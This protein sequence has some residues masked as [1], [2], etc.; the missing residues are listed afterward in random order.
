[1]NSRRAAATAARGATG[2]EDDDRL[3]LDVDERRPRLHAAGVI[4]VLAE[5]L[6]AERQAQSTAPMVAADS[7]RPSRR[8]MIAT[9]RGIEPS[10]PRRSIARAASTS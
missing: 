2:A 4:G 6:L 5:S 7:P 8:G 9:S 10:K 1:M 3:I